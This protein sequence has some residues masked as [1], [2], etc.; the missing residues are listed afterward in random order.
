MC[1]INRNVPIWNGKSDFLIPSWALLCSLGPSE[2]SL[3]WLATKAACDVRVLFIHFS[4]KGLS[5]DFLS[6][7]KK[8]WHHFP[9]LT[10]SFILKGEKYKQEQFWSSLCSIFLK[11]HNWLPHTPYTHTNTHESSSKTSSSTSPLMSQLFIFSPCLKSTLKSSHLVWN[12][13]KLFQRLLPPWPTR[14]SH[15]PKERKTSLGLVRPNWVWAHMSTKAHTKN[16][17]VAFTDGALYSSAACMPICRF[18]STLAKA[19]TRKNA[20]VIHKR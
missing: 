17:S 13:G 11:S 20:K 16:K 19:S 9:N 1:A 14:D 4:S 6:K 8:G 2:M 3:W 12:S 18:R 10:W 15:I 5:P 7:K